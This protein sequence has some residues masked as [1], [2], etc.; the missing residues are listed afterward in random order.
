MLGIPETLTKFFGAQKA[1][2]KV[3]IKFNQPQE[4]IFQDLMKMTMTITF[5]LICH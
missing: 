5:L 3:E 4:N 2:P 1:A